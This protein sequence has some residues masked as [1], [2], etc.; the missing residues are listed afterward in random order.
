M[1]PFC[2]KQFEVS[3]SSKIN[4]DKDEFTSKVNDFYLSEKDNGGLKDGYA[5]FCKH[6]FIENFTDALSTSIEITAENEKF[7]KS[8]YNA[9]RENELAVLERWFN[10]ETLETEGLFKEKKAKYLDIILYSKDQV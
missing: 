5:P 2:F 3:D 4:Y 7:M 6:L 10:K 9:R 1:D 8:G